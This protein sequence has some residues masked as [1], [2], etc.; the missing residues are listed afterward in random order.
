MHCSVRASSEGR[1]WTGFSA[2]LYDII[3]GGT[4]SCP[5][6]PAHNFSMHVGPPV[7]GARRCDGPIHRRLQSPGDVDVVP[8]GCP[9]TWENGGPTTYLRINLTPVFVRTTAQSMGINPDT[10][11]LSP[12]LQ[13]RD[14]ML[15][16]IAWAL[17]AEIENGE[18][19][20]R[21]YAESLGTALAARLLQR[22]A[23]PTIPTRG[24][25][26]RQW[27]A[28]VDYINDNLSL[29]LSLA[30]LASIAGLGTS[31][32]KALF[33]DSVGMPVH[34]YVVRQ[35]VEH[36]M[37]LLSNGRVKLSEVA[38]RSGFVDESHMSRC[39]RRVLGMTPAAFAR[40]CR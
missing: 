7:K 1:A 22:Y 15:Q 23:R 18:P 14:P 36:A 19:N 33:K 5:G 8:F 34:R 11:S 9:T 32:F 10:L 2:A 26:R 27:Q 21:L 6:A 28:V 3:S 39:F 29:N 12:Q 35:R 25:T 30:E 4:V 16:H 24:L 31:T 37:N 38:L 40:E 17:K 13:L 20:E